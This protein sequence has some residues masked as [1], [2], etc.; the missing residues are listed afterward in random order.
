MRAI[1]EQFK[2][3]LKLE[4][5]ELFSDSAHQNYLLGY[6]INNQTPI[7]AWYFNCSSVPVIKLWVTYAC[8]I[9]AINHSGERASGAPGSDTH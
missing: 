8:R 3:C 5:F 2:T 4:L 1:V 9:K 6:N 7:P